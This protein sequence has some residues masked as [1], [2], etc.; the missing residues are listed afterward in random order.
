MG[1]NEQIAHIRL[2]NLPNT[3]RYESSQV[4]TGMGFGESLPSYS[5][6]YIRPK[7]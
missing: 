1:L 6:Q 4:V 5:R 3:V 7:F 2:S